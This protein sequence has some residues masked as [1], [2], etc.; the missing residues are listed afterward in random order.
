M[1]QRFVSN[2]SSSQQPSFPSAKL[3]LDS[4]ED[5]DDDADDLLDNEPSKKRAK[6]SEII[7][8]D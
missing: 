6:P 2:D 1:P 7:E 3:Q 8:I 5:E 4:S